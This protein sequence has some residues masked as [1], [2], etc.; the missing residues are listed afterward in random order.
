MNLPFAPGAN[1][2]IRC[3]KCEN[4]AIV[5]F[6]LPLDNGIATISYSDL[7][8]SGIWNQPTH[9]PFAKTFGR[10]SEAIGCH[11]SFLQNVP[12]RAKQIG[13]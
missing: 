11:L 9:I 5:D 7:I 3:R 2:F 8:S 13:R 6:D 10:K 4:T 1:R 12:L